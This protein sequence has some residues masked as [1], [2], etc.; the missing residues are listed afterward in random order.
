MSQVYVG[1]AAELAGS[2]VGGMLEPTPQPRAWRTV[3]RFTR[4]K[5]AVAGLVVIVLL[6]WA[7]IAYYQELMQGIRAAIEAGCFA[8]FAAAT[9]DQWRRGE[10]KLS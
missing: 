7:N 3:R 5:L 4:N 6:S 10:D 9:K 1:Q 2:S 8:E